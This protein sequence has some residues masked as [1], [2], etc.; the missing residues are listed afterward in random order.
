MPWRWS[1]EIIS[2]LPVPRLIHEP[3]ASCINEMRGKLTRELYWLLGAAILTALF[4]LSIF[5]D[6]ILD[7]IPFDIQLHDTYYVFPKSLLLAVV[8]IGLLTTTYIVRGIFFKLNSKI[9]NGVLTVVT[10][11]VFVG[12]IACLNWVDGFEDH[13]RVL[14]SKEIGKEIQTDVLSSFKVAKG[15]LWMFLAITTTI[16]VTAGYKTFKTRETD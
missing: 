9:V 1:G 16:L 3:W 14:Y 4:G 7:R 6:K 13:L 2:I 11:I 8:F 10:L 15:T 12:L 5:G